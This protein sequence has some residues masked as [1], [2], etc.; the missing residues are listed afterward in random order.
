M[1]VE[2]SSKAG[3]GSKTDEGECVRENE[4]KRIRERLREEDKV[5]PLKR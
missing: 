5:L 2:S 4:A 3:R 1:Q